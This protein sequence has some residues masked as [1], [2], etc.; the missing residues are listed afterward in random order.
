M[1]FWLYV[2]VMGHPPFHFE[3]LPV[4]SNTLQ[5]FDRKKFESRNPEF[6]KKSRTQMPNDQNRNLAAKSSCHSN[7]GHWRLF[8]ISCSEFRIFSNFSDAGEVL[9]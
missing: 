2:K 4:I 3:K 6:Q 1:I 7:F 8:R 5:V 9:S